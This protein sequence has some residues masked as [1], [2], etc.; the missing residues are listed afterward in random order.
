MC[1]IVGFIDYRPRGK[2]S[3]HRSIKP[4]MDSLVH[5]GPDGE[6]AWVDEEGRVAL[7]HRRL[8]IIDLS[9]AGAQPMTSS[10]AR[11]TIVFNG[12]IFGFLDMRRKL[13]E[14]GVRFTGY[15]DTEVLLEAIELYG[16]EAAIKQMAGMFAIAL[17]DRL[18]RTITF[19]RDRVGK[20][21]CYIGV[22]EGMLYF[23]SE[24]KALRAHPGFPLPSLNHEAL[25]LYLRYGYVPSPNSIY[26]DV[27]KLPP[28]SILT[29]SIDRKPLSG[30]EILSAA[31]PYWTAY[32]AAANGVETRFADEAEALEQF[33]QCLNQAVRERIV[34]DVPVGIFLSGGIDSSLIAAKTSALTPEKPLT[35]TVRFNEDSFNEADI[36]A[37]IA[38]H[39]GTN[40]VELT[41]TPQ[42]ALAAVD[43]MSSV[44]DEPFSDPSQL[45]TLLV[46]RLARE[47]VTVVL[48][49]DGGDE[50]LG[51]Y[52]RY[53][54]M[55]QIEHLARCLP[56][57]VP[58][59]VNASPVALL[60][61]GLRV[62]ALALPKKRREELT[63]E[64]IGKVAEI[65]CQPDFRSRYRAS[66]SQWNPVRLLKPN[67]AEP[68][69]V[70]GSAAVPPRVVP[71]EQMMYLDT[72][73]YLTDD[74]L[75]KVDRAS[76]AASIE[77]RSPLLDHR[78]L[79]MAWRMPASLRVSSDGVGKVAMRKLLE[80][81]VPKEMF[82]HPK[83]GFA[84]PLNDWL[85][86]P[87]RELAGDMLSTHRIAQAG[88]F[89]ER[90]IARRLSEHLSGRRNWG[91]SL[92]T[93]M[94]FELWKGRWS[95]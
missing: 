29:V 72:I 18:T 65:L 21:P 16:I 34:S 79:E 88:L 64:R 8:A 2:A 59:L 94:M 95:I 19:I 83:R 53:G 39:L 62:G 76:M 77:V 24:L 33:D 50:A 11:Y 43:E 90:L 23:G 41:A 55:L 91:Q 30:A 69:C 73:A 61:A 1:G 5:R 38:K 25:A 51:G 28:S 75:T 68:A 57:F 78:V 92:W 85:R 13:E 42:S 47:Q 4:M 70:Y 20:K 10:S 52:A 9:E 26:Q 87:L 31:K 45:P 82:D 60:D 81:D 12:E 40:H 66:L 7:G 89:D 3:A 67:V 63:G 37:E 58:R 15:S 84:I 17:Y 36:A 14:D 35:L 46:S 27:V 93:L 56:W 80:R 6:G 86:G 44:F 71:L 48:S 49:G 54:W 74:V 22:S 32:D